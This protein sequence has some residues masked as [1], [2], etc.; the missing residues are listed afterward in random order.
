MR[1]AYEM[2]HKAWGSIEE[3][4]FCF[5]RWS[6]KFQGHKP[7]QKNRILPE[8]SISGLQPRFEFT[9]GHEMMHRAWRNTEEVPF[10]CSKSSVKFRCH[11]GQKLPTLTR[12]GRF[13]TSTAVW[14]HPWLWNVTQCLTNHGEDALLF[15]DVIHQISR[16]YRP[17]FDDLIQV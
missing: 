8:L 9:D 11:S 10:C 2:K 12:I 1:D 16:S 17:K 5:S 14:I 15:F 4:P 3:V 7:Q 6:V 13:L